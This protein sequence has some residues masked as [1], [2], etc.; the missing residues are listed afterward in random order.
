MENTGNLEIYLG[1][2]PDNFIMT[3]QAENLGVF[4]LVQIEICL[5]N[6]FTKLKWPKSECHCL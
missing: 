2:D 6:L 5:N 4:S 3:I 1:G